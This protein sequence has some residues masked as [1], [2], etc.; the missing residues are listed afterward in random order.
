M[1]QYLDAMR[2]IKENGYDTPDRTGVGRRH[3]PGQVLRFNM[4]DGFPL[5][6]TRKIFVNGFDK[7]LS[8]FLEGLDKITSLKE[9]RVNIWNQWAVTEED[10]ETF[11]DKH[12][13][14]A[15]EGR[16][17]LIKHFSD[18]FL[19]SIG[20]LYGV[21]WRNSP[22]GEFSPMHPIIPLEDIAS[23]DL[24]KYEAEYNAFKTKDADGNLKLPVDAEGKTVEFET[25]V[26]YNA[27]R[28]IDQLQN[29]LVGL[30]KRPYSSRHVINC[31]IPEFIPYETLSP[32]ENVLLG[33]GA[34]AP[35]HVMFQFLVAPPKGGKMRLSLHMTQR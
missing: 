28:K 32:Q 3:R 6:T 10:I 17:H 24:A 26:S 11:V 29:V 5:V 35:C 27:N 16:E 20:N 34:L 21:S 33:K 31:W 14:G 25:F 9:S 22:A 18:Q 19:D 4:A 1:K 15:T 23:D 8:W 2:D 30:K 7:E 12:M 13:H